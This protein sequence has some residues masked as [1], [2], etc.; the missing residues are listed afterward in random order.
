MHTELH[1]GVNTGWLTYIVRNVKVQCWLSLY[2]NYTLTQDTHEG[3]K[4]F[5]PFY[6]LLIAAM[7]TGHG[8]GLMQYGIDAM[9]FG[10]LGP[11]SDVFF[12]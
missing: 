5:S 11:L 9:L 8:N 4:R 12:R 6:P 2:H 7:L 1:M 3:C 10:G